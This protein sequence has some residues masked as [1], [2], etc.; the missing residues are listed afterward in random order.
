MTADESREIIEAIAEMLKYALPIAMKHIGTQSLCAQEMFWISFRQLENAI[1][2]FPGGIELSTLDDENDAY[3]MSLRE[4]LS[5]L[6]VSMP[7]LFQD[8]PPPSPAS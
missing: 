7:L 1:Y 3:I 2:A 5:E 4:G 8:E 6:A